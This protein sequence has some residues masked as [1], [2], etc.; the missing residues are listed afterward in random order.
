MSETIFL[1][2]I[3][4]ITFIIEQYIFPITPCGFQ[5]CD[6]IY[7][8]NL[9]IIFHL[10]LIILFIVRK[11]I[12]YFYFADNVTVEIFQFFGRYP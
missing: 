10:K 2:I 1:Y 9:L 3:L 8:E 5:N 7:S 11:F 12:S 4:L 6:P